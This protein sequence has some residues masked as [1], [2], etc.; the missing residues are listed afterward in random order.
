M[1]LNWR[2]TAEAETVIVSTSVPGCMLKFAVTSARVCTS[3]FSWTCRA[4]PLNSAD[5]VY[6]PGST[7]SNRNAPVSPEVRVVV[8][9]VPLLRNVIV[10]PT[11]EAL[12]ASVTMPWTRAR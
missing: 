8:M 10:A 12:L 6:V 1:V 5:T 9:P 3:T 2:V 4:K 11:T 7:L